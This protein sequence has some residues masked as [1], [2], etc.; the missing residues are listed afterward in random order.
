SLQVV[1]EDAGLRLASWLHRRTGE[2]SLCLAGGVALNCVMNSRIAR[3][4]PFDQVWVQPAAGD[5]GTSLGA[6]LA[7]WA[8]QQ[9]APTRAASGS[10]WQME[11]AYLGPSYD[12]EQIRAA[13]DHAR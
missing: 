5:A 1:L 12:D 6:A 2:R 7:V 4:S 9:R 11:S 8:G 3:E 13:L 10:R